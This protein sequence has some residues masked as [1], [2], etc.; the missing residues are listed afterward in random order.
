[1]TVDEAHTSSPA[2]DLRLLVIR[3]H[4]IIAALAERYEVGDIHVDLVLA[5]DFVST[6][7]AILD[8]DGPSGLTFDTERLGGEAVA[9]NLPLSDDGSHVAVVMNRHLLSA[10]GEAAAQTIFLV[11]HEL[12]HPIFNRLR[13]RA[14]V[15]DDAEFPSS[16]PWEV[17]RSIARTVNDEYQ[18]DFVASILLGQFGTAGD[19][20]SKETLHAGHIFGNSHTEQFQQVLDTHV[21]PGWADTVRDYQYHRLSLDRM[22]QRL[23]SD[24]DQILTLLAHAQ[25]VTDAA[26]REGP[27]EGDAGSHR[28][29]LLYLRPVWEAVLGPIRANRSVFG[30]DDFARADREIADALE[31]AL[32]DMWETLGVT[33]TDNGDDSFQIHVTHPAR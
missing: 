11:A 28:G 12:M 21:W 13:I 6:T 33:F 4:S 16:T 18:A 32:L 22:W 15:L 25:A 9:K 17:A 8:L 30:V 26:G 1:M 24:A 5:D 10:V 31:P 19:G 2:E 23:A 27:T 7:Q 20:E 14:G 3:I 29:V